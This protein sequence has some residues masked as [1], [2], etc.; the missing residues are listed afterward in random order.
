MDPSDPATKPA[1]LPIDD[2]EVI[3]PNLKLRLSGVTS[4]IVQLVPEQAR[5]LRIATLGARLPARLPKV[6]LSSLRG[7]WRSP[8]GRRFRI[9]HARRNNEMVAGL[10]L[11]DVL[12][13]PLRVV[14][15]SAGQRRH[16]R[17]TRWLLRRM[18]AVIATS[19]HSGSYLDV[20][21]T[22]VRHGV[23]IERF[24]PPS[25]PGGDY[26][27]TGL[28]GRY[29]IGCFG[30]V[31]PQKGT[32]LFVDAMIA[33]LPRHP[34]WTAV[35]AGLVTSDNEGFA[36]ALKRGIA[37]AGLSDR[38]VFLG[39]VPDIKA[40]FRRLTLFVAPSRNEGFGLTPLEAMASGVA[41][42]TSDAGAYPEMIEPDVTGQVVPA[43]DGEALRAAIEGYM[44]DI[45]RARAHGRVAMERMRTSFRLSDEAAGVRAVYD[46]VWSGR[47]AQEVLIVARDN[48]YGLERDARLLRSAFGLERTGFAAS[49]MRGVVSWL[50][51]R[52]RARTI[53]HLERVHP[54]WITAGERNLLVPN[55]ER[56]PRR[57]IDRLDRIDLILAK[58]RHAADVFSA[59]GR[60]TE[61]LGFASEDRRDGAVPRNWSRFFHL[62]GGSTLKGTEDIMALWRAHPEWPELV[63]V[64]K[65]EN[66]PRAVPENVV[67]LSGYL[68]DADLRLQQ[69]ACGIHLCP[70]R[71][72]GWGHHIVE[73]LSVG[74][75][76]VT[77]DG[78]PMN[79]L[80]RPDCGILVP[81][82]SSE[83]RH[84]GT[85]HHVD[86]AALERSIEALVAMPDADKEVIGATAR[87]RYEEISMA[88]AER[89]KSIGV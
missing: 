20:P 23:D 21:Y 70:S 89:V 85:C 51:A 37:D 43:G 60:P 13:A 30:R 42:V 28:P 12:R 34:D 84:L 55:Q 82:A 72:E 17:F 79:E 67:L 35:I 8:P 88:F 10:L 83:P 38:I 14:F 52:P 19:A 77:T 80:V 1:P 74:A 6:A 45:P 41:C 22:V 44:A 9:W 40:W 54:G 64:Q 53:V 71:S 50:L 47:K 7:L 76:V 29:A 18:D 3:A 32:D 62:A 87:R 4:T 68:S 58:T 16:K 25:A 49:R 39:E 61:Y 66:A 46:R 2:V 56:F 73:G 86:R 24:R 81:V 65:A 11:R 48:G 75:V 15:T 59:L 5:T 27:D 57:Q 78:P 69:N 33:L 63:L 31:R 26:A 36:A